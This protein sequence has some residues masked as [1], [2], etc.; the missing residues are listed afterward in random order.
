MRHLRIT[1]VVAAAVALASS[2]AALGAPPA[3][4]EAEPPPIPPLIW[5]LS[6]MQLGEKLFTPS[7]PSDYTVQ[8]LPDRTMRIR[9]D[10]NQGTGSYA[11][12]PP[13]L[14]LTDLVTT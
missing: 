10:C 8:F 1:L 4:P 5:T 14:R 11:A 7:N 13:R 3:T 9:A 2:P 12:D 6:A